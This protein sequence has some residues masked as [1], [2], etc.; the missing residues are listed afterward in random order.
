MR[1]GAGALAFFI[2]TAAA[3]AQVTLN[4]LGTD[5]T[6]YPNFKL[7]FTAADAGGNRIDTFTPADF[8]VS[9]NG[10]ARPVLSVNCPPPPAQ[11]I[12][13]CLTFDISYS[14]TGGNR[15][16]NA[17]SAATTMIDLFN[18]PPTEAG[19]TTFHDFP[20]IVL[21]WTSDK[22]SVLNAISGISANGN[23][24]DLYKAFMDP[25]AGAIPF[26]SGRTG[27]RAIVFLTD[28]YEIL[29]TTEVNQI[30]AAANAANIAIY[31]VLVIAN[32]PPPYPMRTIATGTG[33]KWFENVVTEQ[34]AKDV[35]RQ[36]AVEIINP[37]PCELVYLSAGCETTRAGTVTLNKL[38]SSA[39]QNFALAIPA[40]SIS[41]IDA[42][43]IY[44][45]YGVLTPPQT[46]DMQVVITARNRGAAIQSIAPDKPQ[47]AITSY[48]GAAPPFTLAVNQSRTLTVRYTPADTSRIVA[49]LQIVAD[50]SCIAEPILAGGNVS[51][52]PLRVV[53]P[54]GGEQLS[55]G[56]P[57]LITWDGVSP[58]EQ[59]GIEY[60]TDA[61][62]HW[63]TISLFGAGLNSGWNVPN[64]P[65]NRCLMRVSTMADPRTPANDRVLLPWGNDDIL[66]VAFSDDGSIVATGGNDRILRLWRP[67]DGD[68]LQ[69]LPGHAGA[70]R[71]ISFSQRN[72]WIATGSADRTVRIW[73]LD[74]GT[75]ARTINVHAFPVHS[76]AF[77]ADGSHIV[78][79][80]ERDIKLW[81]T[82][83]W[84]LDWNMAGFSDVNGSVAIDRRITMIASARG[85]NAYVL[86]AASGS[87]IRTFTGHSAKVRSVAFSPDGTLLATGSEDHSVRLWRI[88]DGTPVRTF[89]G[90]GAEVYAVSFT[91]DGSRIVSAG[92]DRTIKVWKVIDGSNPITLSGHTLAVN[93][94]SLSPDRKYIASGSAD[95][96][97]R[98]WGYT[99]PM[100][101]V[102]DSLWAIISANA[103]IAASPLTFHSLLCPR[104][105]STDTTVTISNAGNKDLTITAAQI[106]GADSGDFALVSPA[107]VPPDFVIPAGQNRDV[108]LRFQPTSTGSRAAILRLTSNAANASVYD[109]PIGGQ[110]DSLDVAFSRPSVDFAEFYECSTTEEI[111]IRVRNSG[112][113]AATIDSAEITPP[114][115]YFIVSPAFPLVLPAGSDSVV[116]LRFVPPAIGSYN[117]FLRLRGLSCALLP[118]ARLSGARAT[119]VPGLSDTLIDFGP[120]TVGMQSVK[121]IVIRNRTHSTM[122]ISGLSIAPAGDVGFGTP[123][124]LPI[125]IPPLDSVTIDLR[126]GPT[127]DQ[128]YAGTLRVESDLP[129][130]VSQD[131]RLAGSA[132]TLPVVAADVGTFPA[133]V[134]AA[135]STGDATITI[136]NTG[137]QDLLVS[138][139]RI[140]GTDSAD[141]RVTAGGAPVTV[142][143][144]LSATV[145]IRF[146]ASGSGDRRALFHLISNAANGTDYVISLAARRE[147]ID[148]AFDAPS[149]DFGTVYECTGP[150]VRRLIVRNGSTRGIGIDSIR[151]GGTPGFRTLTTFPLSIDSGMTAAID[152]AFDPAL[153]GSFNGT[154]TFY[155]TP[156]GLL[157]SL[158]LSGKRQS[159]AALLSGQSMD[160]GTV[161][162]GRF[163]DRSITITNPS[164][165]AIS[166]TSISAAPPAAEGYVIQPPVASLPWIIPAGGS[167]QLTLRYQPAQ[168]DSLAGWLRLNQSA[169]CP[170]VHQVD[171]TG[172]GVLATAVV[173]LPAAFGAISSMVRLPLTLRNSRNFAASGV[174]SFRATLSFNR[175]MLWLNR[176]IE[177]AGGATSI[178]ATRSA[179]DTAFADIEVIE[180]SIPADGTIAEAEFLV[181]LG[182]SDSTLLG[183][184][185]WHW[186]N[187][188]AATTLQAGSF[189]AQGICTAGGK[190]LVNAPDAVALWPNA[191]NP[192]GEKSGSGAEATQIDFY[193]PADMPA[194]LELYGALGNKLAILMEEQQST[195]L[196]S[197]SFDAARAGLRSGAYFVV[198]TAGGA[199]LVQRM[200]ILR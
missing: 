71:A 74:D 84:G 154:A 90:H 46:R 177:P 64:T 9:E 180:P 153:D 6:Q 4:L 51:P 150:V 193:L 22:S 143:P 159:S 140:T 165:T 186:L 49:S 78:T 197:I 173:E 176:V 19:I 82:S 33:G 191:P 43:R 93:G 123:P 27:K 109:I 144:G 192:F 162:V 48:G 32:P 1:T 147:R 130:A 102:S 69:L 132:T 179:R 146:N 128:T 120:V 14:M 28:A 116:T 181:M 100:S 41:R 52:P 188:I 124:G 94:I 60:S 148:Y 172:S 135:D 105:P 62:D 166:I 163:A 158:P 56:S 24:T 175:T 89:N 17:K 81:R 31:T 10:I 98:I 26:T 8:T 61:G 126:F 99:A 184:A 189:A 57:Y 156:C 87:P 155:D 7:T 168:A 104:E 198:L 67:D 174:Q 183:L 85:N 133:L 151:F 83:D 20:S 187:G 149:L 114:E 182:N 23:A 16:Q 35:Y 169:P 2:L 30:I 145:T 125:A 190:R 138:G 66:A 195:G 5:V 178:L 160:F 97:A 167:I 129:C 185:N 77:S 53:K 106:I 44:M 107:A 115:G 157:H 92:A 39:S 117:A 108:V 73:R 121:S 119:A 134:C 15:M 118:E 139:M 12:S 70:I 113:I 111:G 65:S 127:R 196:H 42:S 47:F 79:A 112:T 110:K 11:S 55:V 37:P 200:I 122:R 194:R 75:V 36:I 18:F 136:R 137:G 59:T 29:T 95:H 103:T 68:F 63:T 161:G 141:F 76:V 54:N 101:D 80:D 21:P 3:A 72:N 34:Q 199:R 164:D 88:S 152:V 91:A 40:A 96:T 86:D 25:S 171:L 13:L 131:V 38:S 45:E 170:S 58:S 142:P 50:A